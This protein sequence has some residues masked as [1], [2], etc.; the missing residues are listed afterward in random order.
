MVK[1]FEKQASF[2]DSIAVLRPSYI[3]EESQLLK[4]QA[5]SLKLLLDF[6]GELKKCD[7]YKRI[8]QRKKLTFSSIDKMF[9]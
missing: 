1:A 9:I 2:Q 4:S 5:K 3:S 7:E 6:I 8:I